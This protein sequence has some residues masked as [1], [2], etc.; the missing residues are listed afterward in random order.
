MGIREILLG[1]YF[2]CYLFISQYLTAF[3]GPPH[4]AKYSDEGSLRMEG[5]GRGR[6]LC[7][8]G[9]SLH[10]PKYITPNIFLLQ[11]RTCIST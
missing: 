9:N 10:N 4:R 5:G 6:V 11:G 7:I 3:L 8:Y 1:L 2:M